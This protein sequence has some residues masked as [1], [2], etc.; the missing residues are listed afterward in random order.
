[1]FMLHGCVLVCVLIGKR[2]EEGRNVTLVI[3]L[4]Q[5][6]ICSCSVPSSFLCDR[7]ARHADAKGDRVLLRHFTELLQRD[8]IRQGA[9]AFEDLEQIVER[10]I[11]S[12]GELGI[13][14]GVAADAFDVVLE[15]LRE[16]GRRRVLRGS[17]ALAL[18][19]V[20][21]RYPDELPRVIRHF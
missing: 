18:A 13:L 4:A 11:C 19:N 1:M 10:H 9:A 6:T 5:R 16:R 17:E 3:V 15:D 20:R 7:E 8:G 2:R 14:R 21:D 12:A